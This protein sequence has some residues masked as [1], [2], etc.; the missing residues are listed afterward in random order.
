MAAAKHKIQSKITPY[1]RQNNCKK[2]IITY[3]NMPL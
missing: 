2:T 1:K 3:K